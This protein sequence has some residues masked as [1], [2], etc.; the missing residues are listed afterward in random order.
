LPTDNPFGLRTKS[1]LFYQVTHCWPVAIGALPASIALLY[2]TLPY[3]N[4]S[5]GATLYSIDEVLVQICQCHAYSKVD[6]RASSG[7]FCLLSC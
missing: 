3:L 2:L 7:V 6:S 1:D 4:E 5:I